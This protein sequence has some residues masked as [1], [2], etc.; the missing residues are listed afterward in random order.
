MPKRTNN[1]MTR[2]HIWLPIRHKE[3]IDELW[4]E[5]LGFSK[6]VQQ[7]IKAYLDGLDARVGAQAKAIGV[8]PHSLNLPEAK[9]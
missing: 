3:K 2:V 7:I 9:P 5:S 4:G 8:D 1:D 6:A